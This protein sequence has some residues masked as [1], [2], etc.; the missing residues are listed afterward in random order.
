MILI[1]HRGNISGKNLKLENN[2]DYIM[3]AKKKG[4]DVEVDVWFKNDKFYLGHD[5]PKFEIKK[6]FL[7]QKKIWCH[8]KNF[9][10]IPALNKIG[11]HY[12]WHQKDDYTITSKGIIW[13]YPGKKLVKNSICV[14][15]KNKR[16]LPINCLGICS[17]YI[18]KFRKLL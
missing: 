2:P 18:E 7:K 15:P 12:F 4:F 14:L 8:A 5:Y 6:K 16:K 1:S 10:A 13:V 9:Q 11:A 17:D 3:E